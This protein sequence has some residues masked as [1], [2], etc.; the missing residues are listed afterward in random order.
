MR[1]FLLFGAVLTATLTGCATEETD[2][3]FGESPAGGVTA[4]QVSRWDQAYD[5]G[6]HAAAG[7]ATQAELA[8]YALAADLQDY[9]KTADLAAY[10]LT[11]DLDAYAKASDLLAYATTSELASYATTSELA[12]YA[13]KSDLSGYLT[14]ESDP[15]FS[16]SVASAITNDDLA[17]WDQ[18]AAWGDHAAAGYLVPGAAISAPDITLTADGGATQRTRMFAGAGVMNVGSTFDVPLITGMGSHR[19]ARVTVEF[20]AF[21]SN[22]NTNQRAFKQEYLFN[23]SWTNAPVRVVLATPFDHTTGNGFAV[24]VHAVDND[25]I[26]TVTQTSGGGSHT[27]YRLIATTMVN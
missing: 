24:D 5:W 12:S 17:A 25:I 22:S 15:A 26:A 21:D 11:S 1:S 4:D 7:Y 10:A 9:A 13:L 3:V 27:N 19:S 16:A 2:P 20:F 18:A 8:A 14:A 23:R 6:D